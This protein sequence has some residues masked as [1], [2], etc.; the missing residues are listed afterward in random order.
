MKIFLEFSVISRKS[1]VV[2]FTILYSKTS[3][4]MRN[5]KTHSFDTFRIQKF[6]SN[7][8]MVLKNIL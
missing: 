1:F 3:L 5:E 4:V 8:V 2:F 6:G 7:L